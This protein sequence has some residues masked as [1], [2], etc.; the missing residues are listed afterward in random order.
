[1][2]NKA[3]TLFYPPVFISLVFF[4]PSSKIEIIGAFSS[5]ESLYNTKFAPT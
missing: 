2:S 4:D 1:M 5:K 3:I